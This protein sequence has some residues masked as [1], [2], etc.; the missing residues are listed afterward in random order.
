MTMA[1]PCRVPPGTLSTTVP[2]VDLFSAVVYAC[3]GACALV[4]VVTTWQ[5]WRECRAPLPPPPA[6]KTK[7]RDKTVTHETAQVVEVDRSPG[8]TGKG[9]PIDRKALDRARWEHYLELAA[10]D[11]FRAEVWAETIRWVEGVEDPPAD[12]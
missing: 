2:A 10:Q 6:F 8:F 4:G 9:D 3:M 11:E 5:T 1:G 7:P 12:R